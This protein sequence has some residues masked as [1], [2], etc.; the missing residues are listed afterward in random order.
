MT[1]GSQT[2]VGLRVESNGLSRHVLEWTAG[3]VA[4]GGRTVVLVHGFMDAAGTCP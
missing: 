1:K 2:P 3:P 4:G